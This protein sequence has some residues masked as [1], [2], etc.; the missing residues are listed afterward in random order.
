MKSDASCEGRVPSSAMRISPVCQ[1]TARLAGSSP[2]RAKPKR[3]GVGRC[4]ARRSR[5]MV[6]EVRGDRCEADCS[7]WSS[8]SSGA[9]QREGQSCCSDPEA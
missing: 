4:R 5:T 8:S 1:A 2:G 9:T 6:L 7:R 3:G